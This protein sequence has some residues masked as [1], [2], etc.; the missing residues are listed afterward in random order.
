MATPLTTSTT[1]LIVGCGTWGSSTALHL[2]R[3]DYKN[4]T[5]LDPYPVPSAISAGNDVNKIVEQGCFAGDEDDETW[6][7]EKLRIDATEAWQTDPIFKPYYHE[8]GYI[9]AASNPKRIEELE[10]REQPTPQKGF[11]VLNKAEEF[12]KTM[13]DGVLTGNFPG[14]KGWHKKTGAGWVHARKA[15]VAAAKEAER[16]GVK[17]VTGSPEGNVAGLIYENGDVKGA[18]TADGKEHRAERT[19]LCAGAN[20]NGLFDFKDQLRPTAW[21]LAHIKMT[22]EETALYKNLPVLF[23]VERGFFMEPDADNHE[24]KICDEHPGYCNWISSPTNP[25]RSLPFARHQIPASAALRVRQFLA[26]T[27][28]HLASRPFSFARIC[29]CADTPNRAFLIGSHPEYASLVLGVGGS[30]HGFMH[31]PVI[32]GFI[33]DAMEGVLDER[34]KRSFRWRPETAVGRDWGDT[35]GR[36]GGPDKMM[37]F[38]DEEE[39]TE[40][41]AR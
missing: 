3:R 8:T 16:L 17:L 14:W 6:V 10:R 31:I 20:A 15:L 21:T 41:P 38:Q 25:R 28:P 27:M 13:P 1:I 12:R 18:R 7:S 35:Q 40:I 37:D 24:L 23:N 11:S 32:G 34:M 30:G 26:E 22:Q 9:I 2:A 19:I 5:V 36:Y 33:V 39:W 29:W 4:V